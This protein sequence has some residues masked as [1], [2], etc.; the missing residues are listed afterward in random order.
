MEASF[1][2]ENLTRVFTKEMVNIL[3]RTCKDK[4]LRAYSMMKL[5]MESLTSKVM[6]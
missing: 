4:S 1:M 2:M 6:F 3:I 5:G